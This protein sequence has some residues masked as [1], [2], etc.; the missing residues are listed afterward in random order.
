MNFL[1]VFG[2]GTVLLGAVFIISALVERRRHE[3]VGCWPAVPGKVLAASVQRYQPRPGQNAGVRYTPLITYCYEAAGQSLTGQKLDFRPPRSY[4]AA[5]EAEAVVAAY[6][7]GS[8]V[9]VTYNPLGPQ[10]AAL[11]RGKP[12]GY[13]TELVSGLLL[14]ACGA[15]MIVVAVLV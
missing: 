2:I 12:I 10:Q 13:H 15:V 1:L 11:D 14:L 7:V 8:E 3:T 6:P 9:K 4:A 5:A